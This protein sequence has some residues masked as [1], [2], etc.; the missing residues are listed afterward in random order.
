MTWIAIMIGMSYSLSAEKGDDSC[1]C[2]PPVFG[3]CD[4]QQKVLVRSKT[5]RHSES[6]FGELNGRVHRQ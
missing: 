1:N 2:T 4:R 3:S 5:T 6:D